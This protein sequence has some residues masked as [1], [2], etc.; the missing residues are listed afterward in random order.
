MYIIINNKKIKLVKATSFFTRLK[1][2]MFKKNIDYSICFP[3]CNSIHTFFMKE[4]IDVLMTDKENNI[5][6]IWSNVKKNKILFEKSAYNTYEFP[7]GFLRNV[8]LDNKIKIE[9]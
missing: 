7:K 3:R 8:K 1:G 6:K 9:E 4:E 2:F 5:L